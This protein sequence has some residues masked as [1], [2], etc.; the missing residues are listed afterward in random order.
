[1]NMKTN[2]IKPRVLFFDIDGTLVSFKTHKIPKSTIKAL[3]EA[4]DAGNV[5][6]ISTGRPKSI[7][8][9]L[10]ELMQLN[11]IDGY[12][13]MNGAYCF[14]G[15][16]IVYEHPIAPKEVEEMT[17]IARTCNY[18]MIFVT[19]DGIHACN[20]DEELRNIFYTYL[21]VREIPE[22]DYDEATRHKVYQ[23][24]VFFDEK[25]E[26][27][28]MPQLPGCEFNRWYP[29][30]V[31]ITAKGVTKAAGVKKIME[32]LGID[33]AHSVAFGDG[34]NDVPMLKEAAIGVAMGNA[35]DDVKRWAD[36]VTTSVDND[37]IR[38]ALR[39]LDII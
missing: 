30:F 3:K 7:I 26:K 32:H 25:A 20:A 21:K 37:G 13:T 4:H 2:S 17:Q 38:N 22:A 31:D 6:I 28:I 23:L 24:T 5:I 39:E 16:D 18:P 11:L 35:A 19:A 10:T 9:N 14:I 29:S 27:G 15:D 8:N 33:I 1:M 36:Y 34:G 12:I